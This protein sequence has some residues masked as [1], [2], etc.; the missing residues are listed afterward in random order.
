MLKKKLTNFLLAAGIALTGI[1]STHFTDVKATENISVS[2]TADAGASTNQYGLKDNIQDGVILHCFDWKYSDI[3]AELPNI[4]KAGF[5]AVQTSPAQVGSGT[6]SWYW[7]YQPKGFSV[8]SN[9]LGNATDLKA[10]CTEADKYGIKVIVDVVANHLSGNHGIIQS[11]L[12]DSKYW[13]N[14]SYNS[15][16][17]DWSNRYQVTHGDIGMQDINSENSYVQTLVLNY[18]KEL[19]ALGVDGIRWD[20]A[21]H[22]CLPGDSCKCSF[23]PTVTSNTGLYNY[24]EILSNPGA[25]NND[26]KVMKEY[27][28]YM[29]VTDSDYGATLRNAFAGGKV[30][31]SYSNWGT[32]GIASNKL[33]YW[34]E[35]HDTWS[36]NKDYGYSNGMSQNVIDR[37]Y[38]IAASRTD[39]TA[40]YFSRPA[41]TVK[42]SIKI[43]EKGSTHFISSEVAAVNH[44]HN[45]MGSTKEYFVGDSSKNVAAVCREKGAV[46]VLGSGNNKTVTVANGGSTTAPGTYYD[47]ITGNKWVVTSRTMTGTVGSSG[48]A[49]FYEGVAPIDITTKIPTLVS[50]KNIDNGINIKWDLLKGAEGY[51]VYRKTATSGWTLIKKTVV[52]TSN[53]ITDTTA[54]TGV[55]YTYMITA[56]K[57]NTI[58]K[59]SVKKE[60]RRIE[61][62]KITSI[63]KVSNGVELKWSKVPNGTAYM[64]YRRSTTSGWTFLKKTT[65]LSYVDTTVPTGAT[66][67][68]C[69]IGYVGDFKSGKS[70]DAAIK[71][72]KTPKVTA[73]K[74]TTGITT[75]W[76]AITGASGYYVY[77]RTANSGWTLISTIGKGATVTYTD[78]TAKTGVTYTYAV[79]AYSGTYTSALST[80]IS[81]KR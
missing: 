74:S 31:T 63:A 61:A 14:T 66:Y 43:G 3:M 17:I 18:I 42:D 59:Q 72:L 70:L 40:L 23:W 58:S 21:K 38:A 10:L 15:N 46:V 11:D 50:V 78:K 60:Q 8:G 76:S 73:S 48:I 28:T 57:G 75:K 67:Y 20:A 77:R 24:G 68:Y 27:T 81:I 45:A 19:K 9:G 34:A 55:V 79:K 39:I 16:N 53:N 22:I 51:N 29:T 41:S 13:H 71:V 32:R 54:K 64:V 49:V 7:L 80:G 36:N 4:A 12:K 44:F 69:V 1:F 35:S 25:G 2:A 30:P 37:A 65:Y 62:P 33:L 52:P 47:E 6:G 26:A 5:T 56:Y